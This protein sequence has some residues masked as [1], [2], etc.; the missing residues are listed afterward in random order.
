[1][2]RLGPSDLQGYDAQLKSFDAEPEFE[3]EGRLTVT[4]GVSKE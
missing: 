2:K 3:V 4:F 1:M